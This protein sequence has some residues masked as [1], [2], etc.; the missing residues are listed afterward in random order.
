MTKN[1]A[2][3]EPRVVVFIDAENV[4][5]RFVAAIFEEAKKHGILIAIRVFG[6]FCLGIVKRW[7]SLNRYF[8]IHP[9]HCPHSAGA[10]NA[11]DIAIC[12]DAMDLYYKGHTDVFVLVSSDRD[13]AR[14][15]GKLTLEGAI[16]IGIGEEKTPAEFVKACTSFRLLGENDMDATGKYFSRAE[17]RIHTG[18]SVPRMTD[19]T[20]G[21]NKATGCEESI[22]GVA[23][24]ENERS[25]I[26][27]IVEKASSKDGW[28]YLGNVG[29]LMRQDGTV[30]FQKHG[31]MR[32]MPFLKSVGGYEFMEYKSPSKS[33]AKLVYIRPMPLT[34]GALHI[35]MK[36]GNDEV[37]RALYEVG[38]NQ[39]GEFA[40]HITTLSNMTGKSARTVR[41]ALAGLESD[42][43]ISRRMVGGEYRYTLPTL[44]TESI[45]KK[46]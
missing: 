40:C 5:P 42:G 44:K 24:D 14:L 23:L 43:Y 28:A 27:L 25:T 31:F 37:L 33:G 13:F 1:Y 10:K 32:L 6:D 2:T 30:N 12:T 39:L 41:K 29:S 34:S 35:G 45:K 20:D 11:S 19:C 18:Y 38:G 46:G 26:A 8:P 4:S 15:A 36:T 16:V 21:Q 22:Q 7:L 17:G 3:S 9:I